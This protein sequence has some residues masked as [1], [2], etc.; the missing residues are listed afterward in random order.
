MKVEELLSH[1][2]EIDAELRK[3]KSPVTVMFTDLAGSTSFFERFGDTAGM[4]W[5]E[6]HYRVIFPYVQQHSGVVVKTIGDS[7]MA[8]FTDP[9]QAVAAAADIQ[10]AIEHTNEGREARE[11]MHVRVAL[12]HGLAYLRGEDVFGDVVNVAARIAKAC[13]PAQVL[14]SEAL[15]L[16]AQQ[17]VSLPFKHVG[18]VQFHGKTG[19]EKLYEVLW[20]DEAVYQKLREQFPAKDQ[21]QTGYEDFSGGRYIIM[22]ELGRGAMGVVYKAHDRSIGRMVALKTIPLEVDEHEKPELLARLK[23]EAR[24]A[25]ILDHPNIVTVYDVGEEAGVFYFTMQHVE[26]KTLASVRA[27]KSLLPLEQVLDIMEQV[28]SAIGYAHQNG[29][30]HRDLKPSNLM[31]TPQGAVKVMDFGIAK[32]GD[33]G[34]TKAGVIV[35]T[36]SYLAPEQAAGRRID[37]RADIFALGSVFY[38]L[39]TAEKA[40]PG[41]STTSIVFK[42]LNEDPIPPRVIEPSLPP[43]LD[44]I[45]QKALAKDPALRFQT[46]E[47]MGAAIAECRRNPKAVATATLATIGGKSRISF[48]AATQPPKRSRAWLIIA[49]AVVV[50]AASAGVIWWKQMTQKVSNAPATQPPAAAAKTMPTAPAAQPE[51][52]Q[53]AS[54]AVSENK[55]ATPP[56]KVTDTKAEKSA[57]KTKPDEKRGKRERSQPEF[58]AGKPEPASKDAQKA[59][60]VQERAEAA[61]AAKAPPEPAADAMQKSA[62]IASRE[63]VPLYLAKADG[64]LGKGDYKSAAYVYGEILKVDPQNQAAKD[65]LRRAKEA[66]QIR[67]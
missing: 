26:G 65:G 3:H 61:P 13:V 60:S 18:A 10:K 43:A 44:G 1:R 5:I 41:E 48:P 66:Q 28:C 2:T 7:V 11:Q 29:I 14:V 40:F 53:P 32:F 38:E 49:M 25:G 59:P 20:T 52:R 24:A 4:A 17:A 27:E 57:A 30:I 56:P 54:V 16:S 23:Q 47:E 12:H 8:Y 22:K 50:L 67:K 21:Q 42:I 58:V 19:V 63:D 9:A 33:A 37:S 31:L 45:V 15:Y 36:P 46:C 39:L 6:E 34:L 62:L 35:G 64:Y 55:V 51:S